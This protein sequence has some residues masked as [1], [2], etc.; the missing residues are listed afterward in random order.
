MFVSGTA[1]AITRSTAPPA[2]IGILADGVDGVLRA[3][4]QVIAS[5]SWTAMVS[6]SVM[7]SAPVARRSASVTPRR[8]A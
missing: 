3:V 1:L 6:A 2:P 4:R 5:A 8:V 7:G